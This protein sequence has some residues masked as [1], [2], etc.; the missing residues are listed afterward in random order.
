MRH[1]LPPRLVWRTVSC[2]LLALACSKLAPALVA[3]YR[4]DE[5]LAKLAVVSPL[6]GQE[7]SYGLLRLVVWRTCPVFRDMSFLLLCGARTSCLL[8]YQVALVPKLQRRRRCF[9]GAWIC[10]LYL[11]YCTTSITQLAVAFHK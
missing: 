4:Y 1:T 5:D 8:L 3:E 2:V 9:G 6:R 11:V 10:K 7:Y